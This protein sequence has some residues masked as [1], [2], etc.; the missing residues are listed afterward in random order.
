MRLRTWTFLAFVGASGTASASFC[1]IDN[2]GNSQGCNFITLQSCQMFIGNRGACT[3]QVNTP[4]AQ[5]NYA[6]PNIAEAYQQGQRIRLERQE[7]EARTALLKAQ[8]QE[9]RQRMS[10][11]APASRPTPDSCPVVIYR[12]DRD[13]QSHYTKDAEIGCI[14]V[15][16]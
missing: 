5:P 8:E 4:Q 16:K 12:C 15:S 9:V 1:A 6:G 11:S 14:V 2:F 10:A 7:A 13:G 3:V